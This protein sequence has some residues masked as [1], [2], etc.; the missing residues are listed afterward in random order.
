MTFRAQMTAAFALI[1]VVFVV[2]IAYTIRVAPQMGRE[3][4]IALDAFY[5][6]CRAREFEAARSDFT[7]SLQQSVTPAQFRAEWSNFAAKNGSLSRWEVADKVTINGFG[8]SVCVFPPFV[9]FR[10]AVFG[11]KE[12]GTLIH[13]RM[14]PENG[15]WK[16]ERFNVLRT[17]FDLFRPAKD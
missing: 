12:K 2:L 6:K 11:S 14:V 8:G 7:S 1:V 4:K 3:S 15:Q 16:V 5:Q 17:G 13:V 9:D 10:H